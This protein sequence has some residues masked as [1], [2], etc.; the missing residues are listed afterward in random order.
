M[1]QNPVSKDIN[2]T[3]HIDGLVNARDLGGLR[4]NNG[5]LTPYGVFYRAENIDLILPTGWNQLKKTGI[6]TVVDLRQ[7]EER[8]SDSQARPDWLTIIHTDLDGIDNKQFWRP[9]LAEGLENTSMYYL[10]HL[11]EMPER[12]AEALEAIVSA[13]E[14]G[15]LFH[16]KSGR[17]R[18][19]LIALLLLL[20]VDTQPEEIVEDYLETIRLGEVRGK[21]LGRENPEPGLEQLLQLHGTT[22]EESFRRTI[23]KLEF[24]DFLKNTRLSASSINTLKTWRGSIK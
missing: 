9:Y 22:T 7:K 21:Q 8:A 17:D 11:E 12:A 6:R 20:A 2:R 13:P 24:S 10:K 16:C 14:G 5:T 18:T 1:G 3:L 15:V 4:R 19:G 23:A